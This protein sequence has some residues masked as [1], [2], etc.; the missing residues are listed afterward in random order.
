MKVDAVYI[1]EASDSPSRVDNNM[2]IDDEDKQKELLD[3]SEDEDMNYDEENH[4]NITNLPR[5]EDTKALDDSELEDITLGEDEALSI[6]SQKRTANEL[7]EKKPI[8]IP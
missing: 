5:N 2:K 3:S 4:E 7:E 8:I 1:N 6:P